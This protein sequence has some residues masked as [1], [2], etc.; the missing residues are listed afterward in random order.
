MTVK[1]APRLMVV[2][3]GSRVIGGKSF[4]RSRK[5]DDHQQTEQHVEE[6]NATT[7]ELGPRIWRVD[8]APIEIVKARLAS[9]NI[10][11]R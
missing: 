1:D 8:Y 9:R 2:D 7:E 11:E 5:L 6:T 4:K 3:Q 10:D